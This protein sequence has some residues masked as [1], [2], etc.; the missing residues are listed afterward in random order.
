MYINSDSILLLA[1]SLSS[2]SIT[3]IVRALSASI[4]SG[5]FSEIIPSDTSISFTLLNFLLGKRP[6]DSSYI[7]ATGSHEASI[8]SQGLDKRFDPE[9]TIQGVPLSAESTQV[10]LRNCEYFS[11]FNFWRTNMI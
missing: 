8:R 9:I 7:C 11:S 4:S 6:S 2:F 10:Y 1:F 3:E 5:S